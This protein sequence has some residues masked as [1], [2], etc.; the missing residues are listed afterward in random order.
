MCGRKKIESKKCRVKWQWEG[1]VPLCQCNWGCIDSQ[2]GNYERVSK[3]GEFERLEVKGLFKINRR[4][5]YILF[6][7]IWTAAEYV[8]P[9]MFRHVHYLNSLNIFCRLFGLLSFQGNIIYL[10]DQFNFFG[11]IISILGYIFFQY[12]FCCKRLFKNVN[13]FSLMIKNM[14]ISKR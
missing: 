6:V 11:K 8:A 3:V 12:L 4:N 14:Y 1:D 7:I 10:F 5:N 9:V 13:L 2:L